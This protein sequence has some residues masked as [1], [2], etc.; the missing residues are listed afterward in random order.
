MRVCARVRA[1]ELHL[2]TAS[3]H[4]DGVRSFTH[5]GAS[6]GVNTEVNFKAFPEMVVAGNASHSFTLL[7]RSGMDLPPLS[8][9]TTFS[10]PFLFDA[11]GKLN[12]AALEVR[13]HR[14]TC[15]FA[16]MSLVR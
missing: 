11:D 16:L 12:E 10:S 6:T 5:T 8:T 15:L 1:T 7:S 14:F 3:F 9:F 4:H 13:H 2:Y